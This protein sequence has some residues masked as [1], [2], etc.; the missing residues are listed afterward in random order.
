MTPTI[1]HQSNQRPEE[2]Q[3]EPTTKTT[4]G[5]EVDKNNVNSENLAI[6]CNSQTMYGTCNQYLL[7]NYFIIDNKYH[8]VELNG[9]EISWKRAKKSILNHI[10]S[11]IGSYQGLFRLK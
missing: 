5:Q 1:G 10:S 4:F 9:K 2:K 8:W 7:T 3:L 11:T 6:E